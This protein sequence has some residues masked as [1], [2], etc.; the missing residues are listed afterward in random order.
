MMSRTTAFALDVRARVRME[1]VVAGL[2]TEVVGLPFILRGAGRL[3][4]LD[5]HP[6]HRILNHSH[7]TLSS[8]QPTRSSDRWRAGNVEA[9][10]HPARRMLSDVAVRHPQARVGDIEQYVD[11]LPR[12]D[13][14]RVLPHEVRFGDASPRQHKET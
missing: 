1:R 6:A 10:H 2:R 12:L 4:A 5:A 14:D 9:E 8:R 3:L 13:Q 7:T 11:D